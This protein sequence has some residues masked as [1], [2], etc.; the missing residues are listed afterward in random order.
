MLFTGS[1]KSRALTAK[2][3]EDNWPQRRKWMIV[4]L[5]WMAGNAEYIIL[6]GADS[7]LNQNA[8]V[9]LLGAIVSII[10]FY[11]FGAVWDDS[12]KRNLMYQ[13]GDQGYGQQSFGYGQS[14]YISQQPAY[15]DQP[16]PFQE[17]EGS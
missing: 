17:E 2:L 4:A 3:L 15:G 6:M 5:L 10:C 16:V 12:N 14:S 9:T 1:A 8:L 7:V 11:V 13:Q